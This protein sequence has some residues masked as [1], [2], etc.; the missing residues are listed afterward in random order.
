MQR[1]HQK[2]L[3]YPLAPVS[4]IEARRPRSVAGMSG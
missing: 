4:L 1:V 3:P 2:K